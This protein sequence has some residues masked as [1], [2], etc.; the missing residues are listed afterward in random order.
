MSV[1]GMNDKSDD[2]PDC[3]LMTNSHL[4]GQRGLMNRLGKLISYVMHVLLNVFLYR[5]VCFHIFIKIKA[6]IIKYLQLCMISKSKHT[7]SSDLT[8]VQNK[9][10]QIQ[11]KYDQFMSTLCYIY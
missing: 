7:T 9:Y 8:R 11:N 4:L 6:K 2:G 10:E 3:W 5:Q 1:S